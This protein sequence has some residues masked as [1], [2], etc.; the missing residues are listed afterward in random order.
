MAFFL[1]FYYFFSQ[2]DTHNTF[3]EPIVF[4]SNNKP[5][6]IM[7]GSQSCHYCATARDFFTRHDLNYIENDID[8]SLEH[9]NMFYR[10]G[11]QGTPLIIVN[12]K[13][14]HGFDEKSIR[15]AL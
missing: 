12:K 11:G 2:L 4:S 5:E 15:E 14:I 9:R 3:N 8:L 13:I 10:L 6:I 7:F 1:I